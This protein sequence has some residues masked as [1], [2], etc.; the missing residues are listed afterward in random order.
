[1]E[2]WR[3]GRGLLYS[4]LDLLLAPL[5]LGQNKIYTFPNAANEALSS[6]CSRKCFG[7]RMNQ[8]ILRSIRWNSSTTLPLVRIK[9]TNPSAAGA[10]GSFEVDTLAHY[11]DTMSF[12]DSYLSLKS[13]CKSG[14]LG[15]TM[16]DSLLDEPREE[17]GTELSA[18]SLERCYE[19]LAVVE[20]LGF[21]SCRMEMWPM[22]RREDQNVMGG[23]TEKTLRCNI[24]Y[25]NINQ[26][27][28]LP[29][30][31]SENILGSI[32]YLTNVRDFTSYG[33][34]N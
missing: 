15:A 4:N 8:D 26:Y 18:H 31:Y 22:G 28:L 29:N 23:D 9:Q 12:I 21:H 3:K 16:A 6:T 27:I 20:G 13:C 14:P 1:M 2:S 30:S 34:I 10:G 5:T 32:H 7:Q 11:F 17:E 24:P 33:D 19:I 25:F